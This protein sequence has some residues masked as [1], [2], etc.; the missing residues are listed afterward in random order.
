MGYE[1]YMKARNNVRRI[2]KMDT[3]ENRNVRKMILITPSLAEKLK[4]V[5]KMRNQ[6]QNDLVNKGVES[7]LKRFLKD[8]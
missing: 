8:E 6:S 5:S 7:Y 3:L 2:R 4:K 1:G